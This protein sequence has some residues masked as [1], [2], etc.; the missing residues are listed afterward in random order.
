M[1]ESA[2]ALDT[3]NY[4]DAWLRSAAEQFAAVEAIDPQAPRRVFLD[5]ACE[6]FCLVSPLDYGWALQW[7]WSWRWD[8]TKRKRYAIRNTWQHGRRVTLYM[9][10]EILDR[11]KMQSSEH[12]T[13]GDHQDG[14]SLNN[15]RDNLEWSTV[16]QNR[17]NRKR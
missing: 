13:I 17:R 7:R 9:H 6:I 1:T 4:S 3:L 14:E 5:A 2:A 15:Q 11:C 10:K 16:S 12:H 8:R